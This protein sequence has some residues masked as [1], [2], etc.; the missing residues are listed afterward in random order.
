MYR[1]AKVEQ[2]PKSLVGCS[3]VVD[4]RYGLTA[5]S[6]GLPVLAADN[7]ISF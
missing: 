1:Q 5:S 4:S 7:K 2:Y 6:K 3:N